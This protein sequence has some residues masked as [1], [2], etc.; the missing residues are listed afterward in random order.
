MPTSFDLTWDSVNCAVNYTLQIALD[1]GFTNVIIEN[2]NLLDENSTISDLALFTNYYWRVG[3]T[4]SED[5]THW[6]DTR[7]FQTDR[8]TDKNYLLFPNPTDGV[9]NIWFEN[10][11]ERGADIR[12]FNS[13]G[14]LMRNYGVTRLGKQYV[15]NLS[16]LDR[17]IYILQF[18]DGT[19]KWVERIIV[20]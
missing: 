2:A 8:T 13:I 9:V 1:T 12:V 3:Q 10:E 15:L 4:D 18:D 6:S 20:Y 16:N 19:D 5:V 7:T 11:L 14:Q 17:G